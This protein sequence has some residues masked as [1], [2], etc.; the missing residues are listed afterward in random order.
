MKYGS[1]AICT[2]IQTTNEQ[3]VRGREEVDIPFACSIV[4]VRLV[5]L[6]VLIYQ[7]Y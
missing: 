7:I 2:H 3:F 6:Y 4:G 1:G 5:D